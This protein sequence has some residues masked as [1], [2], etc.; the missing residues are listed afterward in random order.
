ML[1]LAKNKEQAGSPCLY[2]C[3]AG[4]L[5]SEI[6]Y[7][8]TWQAGSRQG[9]EQELELFVPGLCEGPMGRAMQCP[10]SWGRI[11]KG[12]AGAACLLKEHGR[13]FFSAGG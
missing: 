8:K 4:A 11:L 2:C 6:K 5:K 1:C 10:G 12:A 3:Q 9:L 7:S 13:V